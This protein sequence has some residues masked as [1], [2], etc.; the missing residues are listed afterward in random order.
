MDAFAEVS[1]AEGAVAVFGGEAA[2][3]FPAHFAAF[4]DEVEAAAEGFLAGEG[5][6]A[7]GGDG[8]VV[9]LESRSDLV[10]EAVLLGIGGGEDAAGEGELDGAALADGEGDGAV[11]DEGP[12]AGAD[13]GEAEGGALGGEDDVAVG[14]EADGAAESG[15]LDGGDD[16]FV[17]VQAEGEEGL[18]DLDDFEGVGEEELIEIDAGAEGGAGGVK[19]DAADGAVLAGVLERGDEVAAEAVL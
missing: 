11:G 15:A 12:I 18:L 5:E 4:L 14:D 19:E 13:L 1:G 16:G 3:G 7:G 10:D 17:I 8:A 6:L 2:G 9:E